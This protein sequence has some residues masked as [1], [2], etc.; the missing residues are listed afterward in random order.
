[1][2]K[3]N[4]DKLEDTLFHH[5]N[6]KPHCPSCLYLHNTLG[7][8]NKHHNALRYDEDHHN[9]NVQTKHLITW[10]SKLNNVEESKLKHVRIHRKR[11]QY[12]ILSAN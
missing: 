1:M 4:L 3:A 10:D 9:T 7:A 8:K 5:S 12:T 11:K 2:E 6:N